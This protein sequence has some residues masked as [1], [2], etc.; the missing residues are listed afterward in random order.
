M[1][2]NSAKYR[3]TWTGRDEALICD[4]HVGKLQAVANAIGLYLQIIPLSEEDLKM[5]LTCMQ[6]DG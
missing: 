5:G 4:V 2:E 3:Y 6:K 1:C